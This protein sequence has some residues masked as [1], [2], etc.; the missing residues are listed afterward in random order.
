MRREYTVCAEA[1]S[2]MRRR[3]YT[4]R[5]GIFPHEEEETMRRGFFPHEEEEALCAEV[6][7]SSKVHASLLPKVHASLLPKVHASLLPV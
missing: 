2:R 7:L 4:M 1:S 5:R 6:L 3:V